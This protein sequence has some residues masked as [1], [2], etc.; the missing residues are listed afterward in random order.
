MALLLFFFAGFVMLRRLFDAIRTLSEDIRQS[1][2]LERLRETPSEATDEFHYLTRS[3][4]V[5]EM[6]MRQKML[7]LERKSTELSTLKE[8]SDLC[9]ITYNVEDLLY[10]TLERAMKL[11]DADIGSAMILK[12][13]ERDVFV[14]EANIGL[15][16]FGRKGTEIPFEDSIARYAVL[17]KSPL[18]VEN[19]ETDQRFGRESRSRYATKSFICMPLKS[20]HDVIGVLTVSCRRQDRVFTQGDVDVLTPLLGSAAFTYDNLNLLRENESL[21]RNMASLGALSGRSTPPAG[22]ELMDALFEEMKKTPHDLIPFWEL[23]ATTQPVVV[24]DYLSF[25]PVTFKRGDCFRSEGSLFDS[26]L[27][28]R[29]AVFVDAGQDTEAYAEA[30]LLPQGAGGSRLVVFL[31][32]EGRMVGVLL[33]YNIS[34][35]EWFHLRDFIGQIC[36]HLVVALEK[37]RMLESMTRREQEMETLRLIGNTLSSSMFRID[38]MLA[39]TMEMV[40]TVIQVEAGYLLLVSQQDMTCAAAYPFDLERLRRIPWSAKAGIARYVARRGLPVLAN[41]ARMHPHF[42]DA[43]DR[44]TGFETR[45]VLSVPMISQGQV[46]GVIEILNK[47]DGSFNAKDEQLL[48][49]IATSVTIA[50]ENARLYEQTV[51][52]AERERGI[53]NVFQKFVPKAVVDTIVSGDE[54]ERGIVEAFKTVT[55]LNIDIRGFSLLSKKVG[56]Q[57]TVALLNHFI[58]SRGTSSRPPGIEDKYLGDGFWPFS[59]RPPRAPPMRTTPS[60]RQGQAAAH[61][62]N[63]RSPGLLDED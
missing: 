48:Q 4:R 51:A 63:D 21:R 34:R 30:T 58:S 1:V 46:V 53:R 27:K 31:E 45:S 6:E 44:E 60:S 40:R 61:E 50:L 52:M 39:Y 38:E 17:N 16:E 49:A 62:G 25:I 57:N 2:P 8:L 59:G 55:L 37:D 33:I 15:S 20:M 54:R 13:P 7:S 35:E 18:L 41:S 28:Q 11:V 19:I 24:M 9:Y 23:D 36:D 42:S 26:A 56:P 10:L 43:V 5:L 3:F 47:K 12:R 22:R 29:H 14:I 32:A